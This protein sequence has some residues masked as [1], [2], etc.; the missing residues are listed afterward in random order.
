MSAKFI[1]KVFLKFFFSGDSTEHCKRGV[2]V[3]FPER[4]KSSF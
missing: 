1:G 3:F 4:A 2:F